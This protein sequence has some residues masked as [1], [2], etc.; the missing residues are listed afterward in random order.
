SLYLV[1]FCTP[2]NLH[3]LPTRRSSDLFK[4]KP[5][6]IAGNCFFK[7]EGKDTRPLASTLHSYV[8]TIAFIF[9]DYYLN[10][11]NVEIFLPLS[12]TFYHFVN[13]FFQFLI[14]QV[15]FIE[16]RDKPLIVNFL[17]QSTFNIGYIKNFH[18]KLINTLNFTLKR[19][20]YSIL[21]LFV[22]C[23]QNRICH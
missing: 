7:A 9:T 23:K 11:A 10:I 12:T 16:K 6:A 13:K 8:P 22:K 21:I 14:L 2:S 19:F 4:T 3:P 17:K 18:M 1:F 5:S 20:L 15:I